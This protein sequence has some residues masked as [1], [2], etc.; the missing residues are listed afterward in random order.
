MLQSGKLD[1]FIGIL[2]KSTLYTITMELNPY[3][4]LDTNQVGSG[5][6]S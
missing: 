1:F 3:W 6:I 4:R 5:Y 2:K